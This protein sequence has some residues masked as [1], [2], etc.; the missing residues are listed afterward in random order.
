MTQKYS[1]VSISKRNLKCL[2][3]ANANI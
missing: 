2:A 1:T 3:S